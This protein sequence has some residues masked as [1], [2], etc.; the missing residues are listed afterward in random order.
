MVTSRTW[1]FVG[2][3]IALLVLTGAV[4]IAGRGSD[5]GGAAGSAATTSTSTTAATSPGA[6]SSS[7]PA[8]ADLAASSSTTSTTAGDPAATPSTSAG[9]STTA[10][11][12]TSIALP[13]S[14]T[15]ALREPPGPGESRAMP[16]SADVSST[17]GLGD[18][19]EVTIKVAPEGGS[20]AFGYEARLCKGDGVYKTDADM[21]PLLTGQCLPEPLSDR[22]DNYSFVESKNPTAGV[23]GTFR[24]GVGS[25]S[26]RTSSGQD[27]TI[28]CGPSNPCQIVLKLQY[29]DGF[30]FKAIPLTYR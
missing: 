14:T 9:P 2:V 30:G 1:K 29:P 15:T 22:S 23:E 19:D 18:G 7:V 4:I 12:T 27:V 24:V 20:L 3:G 13:S 21:R 25:T 5:A 16:V 11:P 10:G 6:G 17:S 26:F 28:S 8:T